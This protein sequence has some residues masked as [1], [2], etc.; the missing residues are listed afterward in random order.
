VRLPLAGIAPV[1]NT[2]LSDVAVWFNPSVLSQVMLSPTLMV[3]VCGW[4]EKFWM[5]T[6]W[7]VASA[8]LGASAAIPTTNA[9]MR[10]GRLRRIR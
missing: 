6:L 4:K 10:N 2:P 3:A 5:T 9:A 7:L 8:A 1:S